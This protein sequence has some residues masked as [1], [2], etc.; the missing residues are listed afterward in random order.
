MVKANGM[1]GEEFAGM[2]RKALR[3]ARASS[4]GGLS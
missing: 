1:T 3:E 4:K 2:F